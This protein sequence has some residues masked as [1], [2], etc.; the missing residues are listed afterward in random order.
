MMDESYHIPV[1]RKEVAD[2]LITNPDG[3]Y[4]DGTL[5][6]G[7]HAAYLLNILS[8]Q[9]RYI[10]LDLDREAIEFASKRLLE[11]KN[12][13]VYQANFSE[14]DH[15]LNSAGIN[16][17]NGLLLDLGVSSHQIDEP[18]RGFAYMADGLLDMRMDNK[19]GRTAADLIN[20]L[21]AEELS[22]IF[23]HYGEEHH[24]RRIARLIT[25]ERKKSSVVR[26][27]QLRRIID[28]VAHPRFA[29]K[30]YARIFQALRIA[31]NTE[32]D[33]LRQVLEA[34]MTRMSGGRIAVIAYH[35][36]EDR[37]VKNFFRH[38]ENP[39]T[40]PPDFPQCVCGLKARL[41]I[42]TRKPVKPGPEEIKTN[43]R[44]RSALLRVGEV[45]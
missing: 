23:F 20:T 37:I 11:Y 12:F 10:G 7:G 29:I 33:N 36:L 44:A 39:C 2:L 38:Q 22:D 4:I 28:R 19:H 25:E 17:I 21:E 8:P 41:R 16:I 42:I 31:V 32:L 3:V 45:I 15:I 30:S 18:E 13:A 9:A 27:E 14:L 43:T 40:C 5:G 26:T 24:A 34:A 6:G 1:L 35:S